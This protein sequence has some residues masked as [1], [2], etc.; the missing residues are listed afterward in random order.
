[1]V[2]VI[3]DVRYGGIGQPPVPDVYM[4]YYQQPMSYRMMLHVRTHGDPAAASEA[5]RRAL[6]EVAPGFPT[7][8][9]VTL[10]GRIRAALGESRF[11]AQLLS[12]FAGLALVL[13]TIGTYGVI[14]HAVAQRTREMGVRV[15]LGATKGDVMRLV[16]GQGIALAAVGGVVGLGG[17]AVATRLIR[18]RLYGVE[19]TD[20]VTLLCIVVVLILA[21]LAASWI[22]ARRAAGVPAIQALRGG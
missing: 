10:E 12:V 1:M 15:A 13:A 9:V 7:Y 19:P 4:S 22:P 5:V 3:G 21:V 18:A 20:P 11:L 2:G 17:A 6:R 8:D 16:V 14:S